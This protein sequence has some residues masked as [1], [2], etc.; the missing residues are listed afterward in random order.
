MKYITVIYQFNHS[1]MGFQ[2]SI[3]VDALDN[4]HALEQAK[5]AVS[6]T[7]GS[8]MLKRFSFIIK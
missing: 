4:N 6:E 1:K 5:T 7:Y 3:T 2:N 8:K